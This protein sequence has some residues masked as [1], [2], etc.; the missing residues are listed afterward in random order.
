VVTVASDLPHAEVP[1]TVVIPE[2]KT[3]AMVSPIT[4][5]P[6]SAAVVGT[7]RATYGGTWQQSSLGLWPLLF[8]LSHRVEYV[9]QQH[10]ARPASLLQLRGGGW[11]LGTRCPMLDAQPPASSP[12]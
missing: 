3:S 10:R 1:R 12:D 6:V 5:I 2:G 11:M 8:S 7:L 9:L 4:T